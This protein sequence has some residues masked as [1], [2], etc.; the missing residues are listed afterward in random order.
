MGGREVP[1]FEVSLEKGR[2]G[3]RIGR[4][5]ALPAP[6]RSTRHRPNFERTNRRTTRLRGGLLRASDTRKAGALVGGGRVA[7]AVL[8]RRRVPLSAL[9]PPHAVRYGAAPSACAVLL[10]GAGGLQ[11]SA[12][13]SDAGEARR[14]ERGA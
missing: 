4:H 9:P 10:H 11:I 8:P 14:M 3:H 2:S 12:G 13:R 5:A 7:A 1:S 6:S